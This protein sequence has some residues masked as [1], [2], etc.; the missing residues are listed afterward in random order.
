MAGQARG[1]E[2]GSERQGGSEPERDHERRRRYGCREVRF[3]PE[4]QPGDG[5]NVPHEK[6][7][8]DSRDG[9]E[10]GDGEPELALAVVRAQAPQAREDDAKRQ[11]YRER[12][13]PVGQSQLELEGIRVPHGTQSSAG[14][15]N[16]ESLTSRA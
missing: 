6:D 1:D 14:D 16:G 15:G 9:A 2:D 13:E 5:R 4:E 8:K 7:G 11:P 10:Q 12:E 3:Q